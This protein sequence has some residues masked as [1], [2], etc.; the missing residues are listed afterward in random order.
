MNFGWP[1]AYVFTKAVGEMM[2]D[3]LRKDIPTVIIRPT[4]IE[5]SLKE[6]FPG[7]MEGN[8]YTRWAGCFKLKIN[9]IIFF[10]LGRID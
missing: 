10:E 6:P 9:S 3:Y 8:R 7:W 5:S 4:I 1:N 2:V